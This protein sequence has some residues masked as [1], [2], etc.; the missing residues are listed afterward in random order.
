MI[1]LV[2]VLVAAGLLRPVRQGGI[3]LIGAII[4]M[5]AQAISA[6]IQLLEPATPSQFGISPAQAA[7][8]G[9][10]VS[11]GATV[12]FWI[13]C[14]FAA[15]A[16]VIGVR[17]I[18]PSR[19]AAAGAVPSP[20]FP[21]EGAAPA[22][23]SGFGLP[24]GPDSGASAGMPVGA[25]SPVGAGAPAAA[26]PAAGPGPGAAGPAA[27]GPANPVGPPSADAVS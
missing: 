9:I 19:S 15:A 18:L 22:G 26:A 5:V 27:P 2:A 17:M 6:V 14:I 21:A 8:S 12:A 1:A 7:L 20:G 11:S 13:Y 25:S 23:A 24:A 4:P 3:L 16:V 10:T